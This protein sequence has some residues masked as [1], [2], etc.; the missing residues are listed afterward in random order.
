MLGYWREYLPDFASRTTRLR[1]LLPR[2]AA[3]WTPAH[4]VELRKA[5]QAL[6]EAAPML[7]YDPDE[8]VVLEPHTG[9]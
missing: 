2:D 6:V 5:V 1:A 7:N 4:T 9:P 8:P 3:P